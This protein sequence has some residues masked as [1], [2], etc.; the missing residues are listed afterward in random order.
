MLISLF[1]AF[2][3]LL[4]IWRSASAMTETGEDIPRDTWN[5][6]ILSC[7]FSSVTCRICYNLVSTGISMIFTP[8]KMHAYLG[9]WVI[10]KGAHL[11]R[12]QPKAFQNSND[13]TFQR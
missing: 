2:A 1:G 13:E 10:L 5:K 3:A 4:S 11:T 12:M 8:T 7:I 9:K 6:K